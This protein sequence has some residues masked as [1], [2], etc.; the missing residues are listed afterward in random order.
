[1][2]RVTIESIDSYEFETTLEIRVSDLNYGNHLANDSVLTLAHEARLRYLAALGYTEF[3]IEGVGLLQ[4]DAAILYRAQGK[5]GQKIK[6][7]V[8]MREAGKVGCDFFFLFT[9]LETEGE[10]A[11]V[12][13]GMVFFDYG[14]QKICRSPNMKKLPKA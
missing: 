10:I 12:K 5:W 11:Q 1:M 3:D 8:A 14:K 13:T 4:V 7:E 2:A 9:D 6:I